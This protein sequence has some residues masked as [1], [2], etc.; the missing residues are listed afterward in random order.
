MLIKNSKK[1][2]IIRE[3]MVKRY[4][5]VLNYSQVAREFKITRKRVKFWVERFK[6]EGI[7]G[8]KD[9]SKVPHHIPHKTSKEIEEKI[10]EIAFS[11]NCSIGQDRIQ[12]ELIKRFKIKLS[13]STINRIMHDLNLI[14]KRL[15]KYQK[16]RQIR[17]YKKKL[18][19]LRYWQ[20]DVKD[21]RDIP[22]IYP[23]ILAGIF[24]RYQYS[25]RDV[26]T[27]TSFFCFAFEISQIN[28]IRFAQAVL[29]HLKENGVSTSEI[30]F[31]TDNGSEFIGSVFKKGI[32]GF[33][34]LIE[35]VYKTKHKTI[36]LR[37]KEYNGSVE[38]FHW[39]IEK[40]F[41]DIE[42]FNSLSDFLSK[43][44]TFSL[45]WNLEEKT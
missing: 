26:N 5:E 19:A 2:E 32:S 30:V 9:K 27:G 8:L 24:P 3:K 16:K 11:K 34:E 17:E 29:E 1:P 43:A 23:F 31:Q 40:E 38:S 10:K 4:F 33:T 15:K 28:S 39:R 21:L 37:K 20:V 36:P 12:I 35:K 25:A 41:Y 42:N 13:T 44:Y 45:Y 22:N 18:K 14:K 6:K 7:D